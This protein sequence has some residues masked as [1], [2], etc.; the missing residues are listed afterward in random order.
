M[1]V[2]EA[3]MPVISPRQKQ[4]AVLI[5]QG[6]N[7]EQIAA[8]LGIHKS[9][10]EAHRKVVYSRLDVHNAVDLTHLAIRLGWVRVKGMP[11]RP[12]KEQDP[13]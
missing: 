12:R 5:A 13:D 1:T 2:L 6:L 11:G 3:I 9:T 7:S 10:V 8:E 4:V